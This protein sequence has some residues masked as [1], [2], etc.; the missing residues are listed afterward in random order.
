MSGFLLDTN[1]PSEVVRSRPDPRVAAWVRAQDNSTLFLSTVSM[2]ELRIGFTLL[3]LGE[4][5]TRLEQWFANDVLSWFE[6]RILPVTKE[7]VDRR[8]VLDG[9]CQLRGAP[10]NTIDGMIAATALEHDSGD[11]KPRRV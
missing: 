8:G 11:V 7:I 6:G 3:P 1:I 4:R 5:R 9:T 10:A 2:G